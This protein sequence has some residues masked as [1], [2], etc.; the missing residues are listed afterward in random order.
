MRGS[1]KSSQSRSI[2][3]AVGLQWPD[4]EH[5]DRRFAL[6]EPWPTIRSMLAMAGKST[7]WPSGVRLSVRRLRARA[8]MTVTEG[9]VE[10]IRAAMSGRLSDSSVRAI[11][12]TGS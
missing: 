8:G 1:P 10:S 11:T 9:V 6:A 7:Q 4:G 5:T 3:V 12:A 2:E